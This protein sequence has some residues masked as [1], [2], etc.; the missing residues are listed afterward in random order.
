MYKWKDKFLVG[1]KP[2][3]C[4]IRNCFFENLVIEITPKEE[5][6]TLFENCF[7]RRLDLEVTPENLGEELS[8]FMCL[9]N[10]V[11][12]FWSRTLLTIKGFHKYDKEVDI[13]GLEVH[14]YKRVNTPY[15][16]HTPDHGVHII[17]KGIFKV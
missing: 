15:V 11:H 7:I 13:Y 14:C 1:L 8:E 3:G 17:Q 10:W 12:T 9:P 6:Y 4:V 16:E 2:W 5:G